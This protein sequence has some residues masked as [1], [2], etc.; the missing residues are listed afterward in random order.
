MNWRNN[1]IFKILLIILVVLL[2]LL[3]YRIWFGQSSVPKVIALQHK[4]HKQLQSNKKLELRNQTLVAEV[5]DL[6]SG[7][8]ALEERARNELGMIKKGE[9]F[10]QVVKPEQKDKDAESY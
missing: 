10:Y 3:Q 5:Q 1:L 7:H 2:L 8:Q 9:T 6:Q 4:L